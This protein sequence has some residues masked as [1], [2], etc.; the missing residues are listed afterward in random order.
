ML[1]ENPKYKSRDALSQRPFVCT[2]FTY[3]ALRFQSGNDHHAQWLALDSARVTLG[4]KLRSFGD[5]FR[6]MW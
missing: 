6:A 5:A 3:K 2:I 4:E 1:V